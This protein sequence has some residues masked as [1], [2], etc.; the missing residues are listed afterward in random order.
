MELINKTD[1][2][3]TDISSEEY[4]EYEF[5]NSVVRIEQPQF[6]NVSDSGGHRVLDGAGISHYI[7]DGWIHLQWKAKSGSPHFVK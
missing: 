3:F 4:R 2:Q 7:P 1:R 6:L 5:G